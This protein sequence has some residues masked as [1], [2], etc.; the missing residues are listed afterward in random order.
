MKYAEHLMTSELWWQHQRAQVPF[1]HLYRALLLE[2]DTE[3][4]PPL[5][6]TACYMLTYSQ[7]LKK[8]RS[9][10]EKNPLK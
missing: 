4:R 6:I 10:A 3:G 5:L 7:K 9:L 2:P 8:T 1:L